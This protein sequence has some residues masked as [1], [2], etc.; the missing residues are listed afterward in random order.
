MN[1][2]NKIVK[3]SSINF[4]GSVLGNILGYVWLMLMTRYLT[5][6][7]FGSFTLAQSI[8]NVS[9]IFVLLGTHR[10]LDRFIPIFNSS[11]DSG[12]V[13]SLIKIILQLTFVTNIVVGLALYFG[14]DLLIIKVFANSTL[15]A[16]FP[17][18]ILTIPLLA[19]TMIVGYAFSGYK[20]LRY[21]VYLKQILEPGLKIV[22]A[23]VM[24]VFGL[25]ILEWA[26]LYTAALLITAIVGIWLMVTRI[27]KPLA[28]VVSQKIN[29][30]EI[31]SYSWPI[32]ISSIL[33]IIIGQI[34]YLILG[35]Y[36]PAANVG[37]YRIYIQIIVLLKLVLG[38]MARI[39]KPVISELI[40]D[41]KFPEITAT[42]RKISKW[43]LG[44]TTLGLLV[45]VLYGNRLTS[46]LFTDAYAVYPMAL[47]ILAV[48]TYLNSVFGPEGKTL[49][50]FG[51]TKLIMLNSLISL[52]VNVG[53]GFLLVPNYGI[54]GAAIATGATLTIGGL[55]GF[56]EIFI[57][58]KMQ[59]FSI[60]TLKFVLIGLVTGGVFFYLD[61]WL[62]VDSIIYLI[63]SILL[64]AGFYSAG[65]IL[66]GS[67][68][69]EDREIIQNLFNRFRNGF[70]K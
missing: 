29:F 65:I 14:T 49:E 6:D 57:L 24:A 16:I 35:I 46:L 33:I 23:I 66:S 63:V 28:E 67:L 21:H 31:L 30:W 51:N 18:T 11:G 19:I 20:E 10:S 69:D 39:Y 17:V 55:L 12:K 32:S 25:G 38:S 22:F 26:W 53:L 9:M 7:D 54:L 62:V 5:Q 52:S 44:I 47:I 70:V 15:S 34:D 68:D 37:I 43:V 4:T 40:P 59:P 13:K 60:N 27:F 2:I 45:I 58:Y 1:S 50:A 64:L 56:L 48:G 61:R 42:Y 3:E 36:H 8:I 41:G